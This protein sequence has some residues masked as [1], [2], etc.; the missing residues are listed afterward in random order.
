MKLIIAGRGLTED[1]TA[2]PRLVILLLTFLTKHMS[3]VVTILPVEFIYIKFLAELLLPER[4][5]LVHCET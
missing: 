3:D 2:F 5:G 1:L 4:V